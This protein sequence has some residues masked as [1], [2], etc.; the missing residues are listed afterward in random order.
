MPGASVDY[1]ILDTSPDNRFL[2][3]FLRDKFCAFHIRAFLIRILNILVQYFFTYSSFSRKSGTAF[4]LFHP[5]P[6]QWAPPSQPAAA[7]GRGGPEPLPP[8]GPERPGRL[9]PRAPRPGL[10]LGPNHQ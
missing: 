8:G 2:P 4:G 6:V 1:S 9:R 7:A 10:P 5:L 3:G